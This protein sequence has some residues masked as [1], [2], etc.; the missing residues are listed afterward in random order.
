MRKKVKKA[1]SLLVP[2]PTKPLSSLMENSP[3]ENIYRETT[4]VSP[5][6]KE[7]LTEEMHEHMGE[8]DATTFASTEEDSGNI[9][10]TSPMATLD[11]QSSKGPRCQE[12]KG[13]EGA[14]TR[15]KTST[16]KRSNDPPK[17]VN[18]P[19]GGEDRYDYNELM[20]TMGNINLDVIK[21]GKNIEEMKLGENQEAEAE[22]ESTS[23]MG[24][25]FE[26]EKVTEI[27]PQAAETRL[28]VE[29]LE[30]AETLVKAKNDTPKATQK[31]KG[32]VIK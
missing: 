26:G 15:Q 23:E 21:Q 12:T 22:K 6:P 31:A 30:V 10:K 7:V 14:F 3:L 5:N 8:K 27:E 16:T 20:E 1:P 28:S 18:T 19:K 11:E 4:G 17:V 9:N 29:E 25:D 13:V 24:F 2:S 32:V